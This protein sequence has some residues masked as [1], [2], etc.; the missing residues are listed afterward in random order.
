ME[1]FTLVK[2][3]AIIMATAGVATFLFR[4]LRL[5]LVLG[6]L[7]AGLLIGPYTFSS[8]PVEN[9]DEVKLLADLGLVLLLFGLGLEFS[10]GRIRQVGLTIILVAAAEVITMV[11]LGYWLG[12]ALGWDTWD[13]IFL[14]AALSVTSSAIAITTLK[15][16][17]RLD[18]VSSRL[19]VAISVA[20]DFAAILAIALLT[21]LARTGVTDLAFSDAGYVVLKLV[22]FVAALIG[23]GSLLLPRLLRAAR[24]L[25]SREA[26]LVTSLGLCFGTALITRELELSAAV[27]AFLVG[28]L[29]GTTEESEDIVEMIGPLRYMFGALYFVAIGMLVDVSHAGDYVLAAVAIAAFYI[30]GKFLANVLLV[31]LAGYGPRTALG[32]GLG[33]PHMGEFSLAIAK[34]GKQYDVVRSSLY[35]AV[36]IASALVALIS[37]HL[38]QL[39]AAVAGFIERRSPA[40][41]K[42]Y[43]LRI[44]DWLEALRSA[45]R[46]ESEP[47]Q[48]A[49]RA[50]RLL[51]VNGLI[52]MAI[53]GLGA[54]LLPYVEEIDRL[55]KVRA[56]LVGLLFGLGLLVLCMPS[57]VAMWRNVRTL[58][59]AMVALLVSKR[60]LATGSRADA[61]RVILRDSILVVLIVFAT[62]WAFPLISELLAL[63]SLAL[64]I[65]ALLLAAALFLVLRSLRQIHHKLELVFSATMLGREDA[66]DIQ[67]GLDAAVYQSTRRGFLHRL[68]FIGNK[69]SRERQ[70]DTLNEK[71]EEDL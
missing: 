2:D 26:L 3:F 7:V 28:S 16:L 17:G 50:I 6:Y 35:P 12:K 52:V 14:G 51:I 32:V 33:M 39:E 56:D 71:R 25:G 10:W 22:V 40:L 61:V 47:A 62:I 49:K 54:F 59:D 42:G 63:G 45:L 18:L 69:R 5:S 64:V 20:E 15:D 53:V 11:Y 36:A 21:G 41:L 29:I 34:V 67:V 65:P 13:A 68:P 70:A 31:F 8:A 23:L 37:P 60:G 48:K 57:L 44:S 27:G 30:F 55:S 43:V 46:F 9:A 58:D 24:R 66:S 19:I 4:K 38:F 1:E